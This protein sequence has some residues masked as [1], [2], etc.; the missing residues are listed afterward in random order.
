MAMQPEKH[1]CGTR[2]RV[3]KRFGNLARADRSPLPNQC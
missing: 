2:N 1:R 3:A